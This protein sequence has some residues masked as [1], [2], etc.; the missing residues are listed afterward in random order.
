MRRVDSC[1]LEPEERFRNIVE[2]ATDLIALYDLRFRC[3]YINPAAETVLGWAPSELLLRKGTVLVPSDQRKRLAS[4]FQKVVQSGT[5]EI[6]VLRLSGPKSRGEYQLKL[7]PEKDPETGAVVTVIGVGRDITAMKGLE[8]DLRK[9][10]TAKSEFLANMSHE[11][12]TPL[13]GILGMAEMALKRNLPADLQDDLR[14]ISD[15]AASLNRI[16]NDILDFSKIEAGK[17]E[18]QP[19]EFELRPMLDGVLKTFKVPAQSKAIG[20]FLEI[21]REVP[22]TVLGDQH[23]LKQILSNLVSNAI[24]FTDRGFVRV[25]VTAELPKG[26]QHL[27]RFSVQDTGSGISKSRMGRLFQS[28]TQLD[29]SAAK[30]HKGTGLG[31]TISRKLAR[32]M[33]GDIDVRSSPG[34]GSTFTLGVPLMGAAPSLESHAPRSGASSQAPGA[35]K[36]LLAEDNPVNQAFLKRF[37][38]GHGHQVHSA[39]NGLEVLGIMAREHFDLVLMD[40][41]MPEMDGIEATR[42]I[43]SGSLHGVDPGTPIVALTAYAMRGDRERFLE[44]GMTAYVSKP[45]D[46]LEL[47]RVIRDFGAGRTGT[48]SGKQAA[49]PA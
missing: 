44:A 15:S 7:V 47:E 4:T 20:L 38:G 6:L 48:G 30:R 17:I 26:G 3:L 43:R 5:E 25:Q 39:G 13:A 19:R 14:M 22:T 8:R 10:S 40:I 12:R 23:R 29:L 16:I 37:L 31:L 9:A 49:E 34:Q 45:V 27:L 36:I 11:I 32:I 21:G 18:L 35:L 42:R 28:F 41:Q 33:G 2:N 24:K 46:F 1:T